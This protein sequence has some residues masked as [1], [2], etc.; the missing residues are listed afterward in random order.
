MTQHV[1]LLHFLGATSLRQLPQLQVFAK[2]A[3]TALVMLV[4]V[5]V[6]LMLV[7][8][9]VV[10]LGL[11]LWPAEGR[12]GRCQCRDAVAPPP[13][14]AAPLAGAALY[15]WDVLLLCRSSGPGDSNTPVA[16]GQNG[17]EFEQCEK[18]KEALGAA[19][20]WSPCTTT[21]QWAAQVV[22]RVVALV[23][24]VGLAELVVVLERVE[25]LVLWE[26]VVLVVVV[27][28]AEVLEVEV[29]VL[30]LV[31]VVDSVLEEV[32][33]L[34]LLELLVLCEIVLVLV[35]VTVAEVLEVEVLV[36]V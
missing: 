29:P 1:V 28:V 10:M 33:V 14:V 35:L 9:T 2:P 30:V 6:L 11:K 27:T 21:T 34:V 19:V 4:A 12:S 23:A 31:P 16:K 15:V 18:N 7:V 20:C 5:D 17:E 25:L 8:L 13:L 24:L 3:L 22:D 36:L 32:V 26:I